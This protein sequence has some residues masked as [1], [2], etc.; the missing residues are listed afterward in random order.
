M[1]PN[2]MQRKRK[3]RVVNGNVSNI[4]VFP[5]QAFLIINKVALRFINVL[6]DFDESFKKCFY[7]VVC[8]WQKYFKELTR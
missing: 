2:L 4:K 6:S 7:I 3:K 5:W 8:I 1:D